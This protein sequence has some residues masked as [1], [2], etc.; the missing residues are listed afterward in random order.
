MY[1][2][3]GEPNIAERLPKLFSMKKNAWDV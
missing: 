3:A 2:I 1:N